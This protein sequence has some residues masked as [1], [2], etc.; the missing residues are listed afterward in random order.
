MD[1]TTV[2]TFFMWC[3]IINVGM[4]VLNRLV[5]AFLSDLSYRMNTRMFSISRETL[6]K[7]TFKVA[8]LFYIGLFEILVIVFNIIPCIALAI[9]EYT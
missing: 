5:C 9:I 8:L 7:E 2:R 1:V 3:T 4:M 6:S